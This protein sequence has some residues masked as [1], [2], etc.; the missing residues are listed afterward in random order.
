MILPVFIHV[1][2]GGDILDLGNLQGGSKSQGAATKAPPRKRARRLPSQPLRVVTRSSSRRGSTAVAS[3]AIDQPLQDDQVGQV[4]STGGNSSSE[5]GTPVNEIP[6]VSNRGNKLNLEKVQFEEKSS[7]LEEN[8]FQGGY[9]PAR[10]LRLGRPPK[11]RGPGRRKI[12]DPD[13]RT[14]AAMQRQS[15]LAS[16]YRAVC[17]ALKPC[18]AE[19]ATRTLR[20]LVEDPTAHMQTEDHA[21]VLAELDERLRQNIA[22]IQ[23]EHQLRGNLLVTKREGDREMIRDTFAVSNL[24]LILVCAIS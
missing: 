6:L 14:A 7:P 3:P 11:R 15:H 20:N 9:C 8:S 22:H 17:K 16:H 4:D 21:R 1:C 2:L 24:A 13:E 19:L 23:K 12:L 10:P 5:P 18:L